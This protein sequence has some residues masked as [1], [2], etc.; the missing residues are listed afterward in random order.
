MS[1]KIT[2]LFNKPFEFLYSLFAIGTRDQFY[3][4][5]ADYNLEPNEDIR[6]FINE[7]KN[8]LSQYLQKELKYFFD[9]SGLGYILYKIILNNENIKEISEL[10]TAV[11][12]LSNNDLALLMVRSFLKES[13]SLEE[14]L[15]LSL[16]ETGKHR[17]LNILEKANFQHK[18][19]KKKIVEVLENPEEIKQRLLLL[20]KQYYEKNFKTIEAKLEM[21]LSLE[22]EKYKANYSANPENF[23]LKYLN[24]DN[25]TEYSDILVHISFF[26]YVGIQHYSL[27]EVNSSDWF[28]LG[29]Y[30][31]VLFDSKKNDED[32][33]CFFKALSD[34]NRIK[35]VK[36]LKCRPWF[37]QELAKKLNLTPATIS[38]HMGFL[39]Q[40]GLVTYE[41]SEKRSYFSLKDEKIT[42][43]IKE[44]LEEL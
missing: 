17:I 16:E 27:E 31:D 43:R 32:L 23:I 21:E 24:I 1:T 30:T 26:K 15:A 8:N 40:A 36:L 7:S 2:F 6:A 11:E 18:D 41:K 14:L 5:I 20:L 22:K 29:I 34:V 39:Q 37:G 25:I 42:K 13:L 10:I 3:K 9:S 33:A 38:Y 35:I 19:R 44:F 12:N 28:I 4:M